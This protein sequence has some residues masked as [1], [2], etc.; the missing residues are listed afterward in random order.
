MLLR[1][2]RRTT[3]ASGRKELRSLRHVLASYGIERHAEIFRENRIDLDVIH[4]ITEDD[5]REMK[6]PLG[7][8]KR[9]LMLA[10]DLLKSPNLAKP[11]ST[12]GVGPGPSARNP[13]LAMKPEIRQV[14][15][16][17]AD[18]VESTK[19]AAQLDIEDCHEILAKFHERCTAIVK[20]NE[21]TPARYVGDALLACFGYP[22]AA[23]DDALRAATAATQIVNEVP[24]IE[25]SSCASLRARVGISTGMAMTGDLLGDGTESFG[26]ATG[27]ILNVASRLQTLADPGTVLSDDET[28]RLL[29]Q[30]F[31]FTDQGRHQLKGFAETQTIWRIE[32]GDDP[33]GSHHEAL[34]PR[35]TP[36]VGREEELGLLKQRWS[37]AGRKG[38]VVLVTGEAGIGKSRLVGTFIEQ[39]DLPTKRVLRMECS[40]HEI[41]RPLHPM[42]KMIELLA[43]ISKVRDPSTRFERLLAWVDRELKLSPQ[44]ANVL[45]KLVSPA[46]SGTENESAKPKDRKTTL[47]D[48]LVQLI[49]RLGLGGP[50]LYLLEDMH[51]IDPTTQEFLDYLVERVAPLRAMFVCTY[52]PEHRPGFIS[53]PRVM[54]ISLSRL[55]ADQSSQMIQCV[56]GNAA[57]SPDLSEEIVAR[58]DGIPLFIEELTKSA[59]ESISPSQTADGCSRDTSRRLPTTLRGSLLARLDRVPQAHRIA[60]IGAAIGRTFPHALMLRVANLSAQEAEPVLSDLI[61]SELLTRHGSRDDPLYTFKHALV[62]DTAYEMMPKSRRARIH[63]RIGETL[64]TLGAE[65]TDPRP[66]VLAQHFSAAAEHA[67]ACDYWQAA[68]R[69]ARAASANKEVVEYITF[70][71]RANEHAQSPEARADREIELRELLRVPFARVSLGSPDTVTNLERLRHL[72]AQRGKDA[73]LLS[74]VHGIGAYYVMV[75]RISE[76]DSIVDEILEDYSQGNAVAEI[77]GLRVRGFC[78]FL[79]GDFKDAINDFTNVMLLC[80]KIPRSDLDKFYH[81]DTALI[82]MCMICWSRALDDH[83]ETVDSQLATAIRLA[84]AA[85]PWTQLYAHGLICCVYQAMGDVEGCLELSSRV[86]AMAEEHGYNYW[87]AW[88]AILHGWALSCTGEPHSGYSELE[89]GIDLYRRTGSL[90]LL[91]YAQVLLADSLLRTQREDE[92]MVIL[93]ELETDRKPIEIRYIDGMLADLRA[94]VRT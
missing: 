77:L 63:R 38:S 58:A 80:E 86:G 42:I 76:A 62:R 82:A 66:E 24:R 89:R 83:R 18:L 10:K 48:T 91:P 51:W 73:D 36:L 34:T 11:G 3:T 84:Q 79:V 72:R 71:L 53:E 65:P 33:I 14:T 30:G 28:R 31:R 60:P 21:G 69:E 78:R 75:G 2:S 50:T 23:E 64:E 41:L 5:L 81:A 6:I 56:L 26:P 67:K 15:A 37:A 20:D 57:L 13:T 45:A 19:L 46:D 54:L 8:R 7:D 74:V 17:F 70:A 1:Y 52:R 35:L 4:H 47:F 9:V 93:N 44:T 12:A 88:S 61:A 22:V 85:D 92:A 29:P 90:Q 49:E 32:T 25:T 43:G 39:A 59:L 87:V 16:L 55:E 40:S 68:A 27:A 94:S